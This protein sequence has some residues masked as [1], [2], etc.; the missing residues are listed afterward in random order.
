MPTITVTTL[1]DPSNGTGVSLR[2]AIN[3]ANS[4]AEGDTIYFAP[5][6]TKQTI[7]LTTAYSPTPAFDAS[8]FAITK[9]ITIYGT[10]QKLDA[11]N[12]MRHFYV[13]AGA[14]LTLSNLTFVN[15]LA[16]ERHG[17]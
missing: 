5:E 11:Q 4:K 13:A 6:L 16:E 7:K 12:L 15:G 8:A 9:S 3:Q 17:R 1:A 2:D 10:G 14:D